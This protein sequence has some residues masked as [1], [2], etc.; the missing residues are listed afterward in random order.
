M[1]QRN[2]LKLFLLVVISLATLLLVFSNA[3]K[4][5]A[6]PVPRDISQQVMSPYKATL[7]LTTGKENTFS[8]SE[9]P[10]TVKKEEAKISNPSSFLF[11]LPKPEGHMMKL[12]PM[13]LRG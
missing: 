5:R 3:S 10:G 4:G 2:T 1:F 8:G 6:N 9:K 13:R 12:S 7:G 11:H